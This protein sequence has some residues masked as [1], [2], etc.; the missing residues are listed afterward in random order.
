MSTTSVQS[1]PASRPADGP[2]DGVFYTNR[3]GN[4]KV[5][6]CGRFLTKLE[7]LQRMDHPRGIC[8]WCGSNGFRSGNPNIFEELLLPRSWKLWLAIRAGILPPPPSP[9]D[10]SS[11][12][13]SMIS[14][15]VALD[16]DMDAE[17]REESD[18]YRDS[19]DE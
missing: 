7:I 3:C 16:E 4:S 1:A 11:S 10:I 6:G 14:Q 12:R 8:P 19:L 15:V 13:N 2:T 5:P 18:E 9:K 17:D